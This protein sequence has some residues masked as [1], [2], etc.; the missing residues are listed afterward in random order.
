MGDQ[1]FVM[2]PPTHRT[3]QTKNKNMQAS[4]PTDAMFERARQF[5]HQIALPLKSAKYGNKCN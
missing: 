2:S 1:I 3:T 4:T 5:I